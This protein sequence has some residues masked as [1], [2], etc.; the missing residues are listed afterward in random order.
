M[1]PRRARSKPARGEQ[2]RALA[3]ALAFRRGA[4]LA[5]REGREGVASQSEASAARL[6]ASI[7]HPAVLARIPK[8]EA[9]F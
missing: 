5:R 6:F 2:A 9:P 4:A 1:K 8:D 7:H 3:L